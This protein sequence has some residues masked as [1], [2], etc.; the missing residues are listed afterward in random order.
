M[1]INEKTGNPGSS[2]EMEELESKIEQ[3]EK[4]LMTEK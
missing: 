4:E 1:S 2:R 3:L